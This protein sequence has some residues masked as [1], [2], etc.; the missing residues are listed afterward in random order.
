MNCKNLSRLLL[1]LVMLVGALSMSAA[2]RDFAVVLNNGTGTLL[3]AEEQ[4]QGTAVNFGVTVAE[5]GTVTRVAADAEGVAA[6]VEG[7]FHSEHGLNNFVATVPVEGPVKITLAQCSYGGDATV[8]N[9]F[10]V[11]WFHR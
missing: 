10:I 9:D 1:V 11:S 5:D 7:K 3:T 2:F 8:V 4:V 6:V